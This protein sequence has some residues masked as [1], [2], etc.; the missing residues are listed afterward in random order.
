MNIIH[1]KAPIS[2]EDL[3]AYFQNKDTKYLIDY[4]NLIQGL[5]IN[6]KS[7]LKKKDKTLKLLSA[8]K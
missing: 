4:A 7:F 5:F 1:T 2:I 3:K 8:A 6:Q